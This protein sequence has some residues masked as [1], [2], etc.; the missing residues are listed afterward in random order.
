MDERMNDE[1]M[2]GKGREAG[3]GLG[4]FRVLDLSGSQ[5]ERCLFWQK[6]IS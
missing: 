2:K 1:G 5:V 6:I 3:D 4:G